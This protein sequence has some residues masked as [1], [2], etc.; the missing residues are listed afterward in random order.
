MLVELWQYGIEFSHCRLDQSFLTSSYIV[1]PATSQALSLTPARQLRHD[2]AKNGGAPHPLVI[3]TQ[4][5]IDA[6]SEE[7]N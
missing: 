4:E 5:V 1:L 6:R 2:H 7:R 3:G